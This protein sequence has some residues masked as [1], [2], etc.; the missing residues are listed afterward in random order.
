MSTQSSLG[1]AR[2]PLGW[3]SLIGLLLLVGG[4]LLFAQTIGWLRLGDWLWGA[5]AVV[6]AA[7]FAALW[8]RDRAQW[9]VFIPAGALLGV[10]VVV[11]ST[12]WRTIVDPGEE[13]VGLLFLM[14]FGLGFGLVYLAERSMWWALIPM[15]AM[16]T[17]ATVSWL[18]LRNTADSV[19]AATMFFG[20]AA[21]FLLVAVAPGGRERLRWWALIP[22]ALLALVGVLVAGSYFSILNLIGPLVLMAIGVG[23]LVTVLLRRR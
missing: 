16:W 9:W 5:A 15:G 6:A 7:F 11:L 19:T 20:M 3:R 2:S 23:L 18:G 21:T 14:F 13:A 10:A 17:S 1:N 12:Y 22:T 8:M 4:A